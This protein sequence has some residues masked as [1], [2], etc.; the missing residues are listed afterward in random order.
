MVLLVL[1]GFGIPAAHAAKETLYLRDL[2]CE[3]PTTMLGRAKLCDDGT[4]G[5]RG[6]DE[7]LPNMFTCRIHGRP[8]A[9]PAWTASNPDCKS[10]LG[11]AELCGG[12]QPLLIDSVEDGRS[13]GK[14]YD[15]CWGL[16]EWHTQS[17]NITCCPCPAGF[18]YV[19]LGCSPQDALWAIRINGLQ[20]LCER[21]TQPGE[22]LGNGCLSTFTCN[23]HEF[24]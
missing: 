3:P 14:N 16:L 6:S 10:D 11:D 12:N 9:V 2:A 24:C 22:T 21:C 5:K 8:C 15:G 4:Q 20:P 19:G 13:H 1:A 18:T 17:Y 7:I 23:L